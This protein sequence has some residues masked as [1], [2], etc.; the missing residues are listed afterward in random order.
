LLAGLIAIVALVGV[1]SVGS[2]VNNVLWQAVSSGL[3]SAL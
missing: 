3:T 2:A 1:T